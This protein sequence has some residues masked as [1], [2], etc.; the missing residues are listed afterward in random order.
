MKKKIIFAMRQ[1]SIYVVFHIQ[2]LLFYNKGIV[3]LS[4]YCNVKGDCRISRGLYPLFINL[5]HFL[6]RQ[7]ENNVNRLQLLTT[8]QNYISKFITFR[9]FVNS[10]NLAI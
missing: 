9:L 3:P 4:L 8:L 1:L 5:T 2:S 7:T 6:M 10:K